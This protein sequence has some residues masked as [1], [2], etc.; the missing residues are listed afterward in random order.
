MTEARQGGGADQRDR[1]LVTMQVPIQLTG[2]DGLVLDGL[3]TGLNGKGLAGR[4]NVDSGALPEPAEGTRVQVTLDL[5]KEHPFTT[6]EGQILRVEASW[7][8]GHRY[9]IAIRFER[10]SAEDIEY[11]K[12]FIRWR[13]YRYYRQERP[14]RSWFLFSEHEHRQYGP[15]TTSEV[16]EA[17]RQKAVTDADLIWSKERGEWVRFTE[18]TFVE[19]AAI[20]RRRSWL[21][22]AAGLLLAV[23]LGGGFYGYHEGWFDFGMAARRYRDGCRLMEKGNL[24]LADQRFSDVIRMDEGGPWAERALEARAL[25]IR[26]QQ[27][28]LSRQAAREKLDLLDKI[29][30]DKQSHPLV[31]NNFGDCHYRLDDPEKA[32][33]F[34]LKAQEKSPDWV[35][36]HYN[37]GTTY[38]RLGNYESALGHFKRAQESLR[39]VPNLF[40]NMGL[41]CLALDR[42]AE[43]RQCFDKAAFLAPEDAEVQSTIA[44]ALDLE[45][46]R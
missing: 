35:R 27:H 29:P 26:R 28:D 38:L 25:T 31:L 32:L 10:I 7:T 20:P 46:T 21:G 14:A 5:P 13:E 42:R 39:T 9:F 12:R 36:L 2:P 15:L 16:I 45:V 1:R 30:L 3:T 33:D 11:L 23:M 24:N 41:A 44:R 37:I 4:F 22:L 43:A 40:L 19:I 8:P 18:E 34:F 17:V 6:I